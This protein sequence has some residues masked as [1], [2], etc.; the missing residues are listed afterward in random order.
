M[1]FH[2]GETNQGLVVLAICL[3]IMIVI[4][5]II[6][7]WRTTKEE[8]LI[9]RAS[10]EFE[11]GVAN[12]SKIPRLIWTFWNKQERPESVQ[13]FMDLMKLYNPGYDVN[14]L[15]EGSL[16]TYLP[17]YFSDNAHEDPKVQKILKP[18]NQTAQ[19]LADFV[20]IELLRK[21]GGIWLDSS[22]MLTAP[23]SWV[24]ATQ[25]NTK[26][27]YVGYYIS[28]FQNPDMF[29][30]APVIENWFMACVP[31]SKFINDLATEFR[32][33]SEFETVE[34]YIA[35]MKKNTK[36]DLQNLDNPYYLSMHAAA[37]AVLQKKPGQYKLYVYMAEQGPFKYLMENEWKSLEAIDA[38]FGNTDR[39]I[40]VNPVIKLRGPERD[41]MMT[42]HVEALKAVVH[43][44]RGSAPA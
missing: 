9:S 1:K 16:K 26:A 8:K 20:R 19:R 25:K 43:E 33:L 5:A 23:L 38:L 34:D 37:Q 12:R 29:K 7:V 10:P 14:I 2:R 6:H 3:I 17:E 27:E 11:F 21:Y 4:L 42:T 39:Y 35:D 24:H 28:L 22:I 13:L 32:R 31:G 44:M 18:F 41:S 15:H 30:V 40:K 36:T